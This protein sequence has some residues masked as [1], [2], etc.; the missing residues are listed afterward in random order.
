MVQCIQLYTVVAT[1]LHWILI[2]GKATVCYYIEYYTM[3][4]FI[5]QQA[6]CY[7]IAI[8]YA[9]EVTC[10]GLTQIATEFTELG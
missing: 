10:S 2:T 9:G 5:V 3:S 8:S 6:M 1:H 7:N 4:I